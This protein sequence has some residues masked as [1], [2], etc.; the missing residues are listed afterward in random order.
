M[1]LP[2]SH[3]HAATPAGLAPAGDS[4][5]RHN[6]EIHRNRSAWN[7]KPILR[8]ICGQF[9]RQIRAELTTTAPGITLELGSGLGNIKEHI[10][11]CVTSDLFPNPWL[12]RQENAYA[13]TCQPDSVANLILFDVWHHLR[14]PG[15]ALRE[16]HRVL[17]PGGRLVLFEPAASWCG[18][19]IYQLFHHERVAL[20]SA[21][22][23]EAPAGFAPQDADY[24]TAQGSATRVFWWREEPERLAGWN[25]TVVRPVTSFAYF[26]SGGF[27]GPS[28]AGTFLH[29]LLNRLD[30]K[31]AL[32]PRAFAARLLVVLEKPAAAR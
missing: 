28:L 26:A 22:S 30:R 8:A 20:G 5:R 2:L 6:V 12:D 21:I 29:N 18:R 7:R 17:A 23:W 24:Y 25:V 13:L 11:H 15:P 10:P 3:P 1:S 16:F 19:V 14:Y 31:I 27:S 4:V 9:Y 32:W